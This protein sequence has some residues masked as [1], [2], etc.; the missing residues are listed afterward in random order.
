MLIHCIYTFC[1][2]NATPRW[3][4]RSLDLLL[5]PYGVPRMVAGSIVLPEVVAQWGLR[6]IH[7]LQAG[8]AG[9]SDDHL[10]RVRDSNGDVHRSVRC[11][12]FHNVLD[13]LRNLWGSRTGSARRLLWPT[14]DKENQGSH[15][16]HQ[17]EVSVGPGATVDAVH[18][19]LCATLIIVNP[20][21]SIE[22]VVCLAVAVNIIQ[23]LLPLI[24]IH[25]SSSVV[26]YFVTVTL[27]IA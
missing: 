26:L 21:M 27:P 18:S 11:R 7:F 9:R 10:I 3:S 22:E 17:L 25:G 1:V 13:A 2:R 19:I 8:P 23:P 24:R 14:Y 5:L 16:L 6:R 4:F 20:L 15:N 12:S